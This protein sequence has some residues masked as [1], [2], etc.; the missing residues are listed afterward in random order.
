MPERLNLFVMSETI[1]LDEL[2][3]LPKSTKELDY[4]IKFLENNQKVNL[5]IGS[6]SEMSI[7]NNPGSLV[8]EAFNYMIANGADPG[9]VVF[10]QQIVNHMPV[11]IFV[12]S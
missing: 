10:N 5:K 4:L 1:L 6:D 7:D 2:Y 8:Q 9:R 3:L 12:R 11:Y